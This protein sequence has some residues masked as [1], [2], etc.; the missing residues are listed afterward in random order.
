MTFLLDVPQSKP[1]RAVFVRKWLPLDDC[2]WDERGGSQAALEEPSLGLC[3]SQSEERSSRP[4]SSR[5]VEV[6]EQAEKVMEEDTQLVAM[7]PDASLPYEQ[8]SSTD[9]S[10]CP[11]FQSLDELLSSGKISRA[12]ADRLKASYRRLHGAVERSQESQIKLLVEVERSRAELARAQDCL[13][14]R[15]QCLEREHEMQ[16]KPAAEMALTAPAILNEV[17]R[18]RENSDAMKKP[19]ALVEETAVRKK[20]LKEV[21]VEVEEHNRALEEEK[22]LEGRRAQLEDSQREHRQQLKELEFLREENVVLMG[23][24]ARLDLKLQDIEIERK[25]LC[26]KKSRLLKELNREMQALKRSGYEKELSNEQL[27]HTQSIEQSVAEEES[28]KEQQESTVQELL[29]ESNRLREELQNLIHLTQIKVDE[30]DRKH[31]EMLRAERVEQRLEQQLQEKDLDIMEHKKWIAVLQRRVSVHTTICNKITADKNKYVNAKQITSQTFAELTGQFKIL[32]NKIEMQRSIAIKM[33]RSLAT[34]RME[35]CHS[36]KVRDSLRNSISKEAQKLSEISKECEDHKVEVENL[37]HMI[38]IKEQALLEMEKSHEAAI[39]SRNDLGIQLLER[40]EEVCILSEKGN[41]LKA[42]IAKGNMALV[43]LEEETRGLGLAISEEKRQIDLKNKELPRVRK[44]EDEV[45]VLKI[46]LL[47][48]NDQRLELEKALDARNQESATREQIDTD[49]TTEELVKKIEQ[50]E[51]RLAEREEK[52]SELKLRQDQVTRLCQPL[53]EQVENSKLDRLQ[54]AK[55][56]NEKRSYL[57]HLDTRVKALTAE[58]SVAKSTF[59]VEEQKVKEKKLKLET[60]KQRLEQGLPPCP[61]MEE[62]RRKQL[63]DKRRRQRDKQERERLAEEK[64]KKLLP[65]GVYTT[66]EARPSAYIP[67]TDSLLPLPKPYGAMAPFKPSKPGANMRHFR[68]PKQ[69]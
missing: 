37:T 35:L 44:L 11:A 6:E 12:Q 51:A 61:E 63:R 18:S 56:L 30:R 13:Q 38:D 1:E 28:L 45:A 15:R 47:K 4:P 42:I 67:Q 36:Y 14:E 62:V 24:R 32:D 59:L 16:P 33:D 54:L 48:A 53:S 25:F 27:E 29:G 10:A 41:V 21:E 68:K 43:T 19:E 52:V 66:A 2:G 60:C 55:K 3:M 22:E 26:E 46:E 7:A 34:A 8:P 50:L 69:P 64:Q 49:P 40:E 31:W 23:N 57:R 9:L 5:E 58:V 39:Q 20:Q 17:E 65:S